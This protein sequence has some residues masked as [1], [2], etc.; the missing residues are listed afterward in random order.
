MPGMDGFAFLDAIGQRA[1]WRALPIVVLTAKR[2]DAAEREVL[3]G[4]TREV[5]AKGADDL[6]AA[7]R[8]HLRR[9]PP[10]KTAPASG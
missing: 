10:G 2:L 1:E 7:L 8:R 3:A 5:L 6:A 4:R 9:A